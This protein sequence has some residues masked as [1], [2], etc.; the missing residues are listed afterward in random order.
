MCGANYFVLRQGGGRIFV[1][2]L[3]FIMKKLIITTYNRDIV[4]QHDPPGT[5]LIQFSVCISQACVASHKWKSGVLTFQEKDS[6]FHS[7]NFTGKPSHVKKLIRIF[8][9]VPTVTFSV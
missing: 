5:N 7:V 4:S 3:H 9:E 1:T 2:M 8:T 6:K